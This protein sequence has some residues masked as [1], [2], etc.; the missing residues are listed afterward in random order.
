[1][2]LPNI[3]IGNEVRPMTDAE[4]AQW[5]KDAVELEAAAV[6]INQIATARSSALA[7]LAAIGLTEAEISAL[8]G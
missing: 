6:A 5:Q 2:E 7:K 1:M 3:Q 8:V 4:F